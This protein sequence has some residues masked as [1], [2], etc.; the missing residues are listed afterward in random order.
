M[1]SFGHFVVPGQEICKGVGKSPWGFQWN[2]SYNSPLAFMA[3]YFLH[4]CFELIYFS[5]GTR[6]NPEV[7]GSYPSPWNHNIPIPFNAFQFR[8]VRAV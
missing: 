6:E 4:T 7:V 2:P 1:E 5:F 8:F 3:T